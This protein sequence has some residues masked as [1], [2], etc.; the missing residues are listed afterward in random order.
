MRR[1]DQLDSLSLVAGLVLIV[2]GSVLLLA[3]LDAITLDFAGLAP[4]ALGAVGAILLVSGLSRGE[5]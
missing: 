2:L 5:R 4:I 1:R 3:A